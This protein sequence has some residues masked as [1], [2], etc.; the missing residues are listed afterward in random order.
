MQ[1]VAIKFLIIRTYR[2]FKKLHLFFSFSDVDTNFWI[3][4]CNGINVALKLQILQL[5]LL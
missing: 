1:I 4:P 3:V 2:A 5:R